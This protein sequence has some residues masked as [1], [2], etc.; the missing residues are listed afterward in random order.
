MSAENQENFVSH[1]DSHA[2]YIAQRLIGFDMS[3][4][5]WV[6][7]VIADKVSHDIFSGVLYVDSGIDQQENGSIEGKTIGRSRTVNRSSRKQL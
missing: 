2:N 7:L 3:W 5:E 4:N 6:I 1:I